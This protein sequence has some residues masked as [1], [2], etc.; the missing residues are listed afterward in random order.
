MV[1]EQ[2]MVVVIRRQG[3]PRAEPHSTVCVWVPVAVHDR[4][5]AVAARRGE[6]VSKVAADVLARSMADRRRS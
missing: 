3:R 1:S 2:S 6:S 5:I 4:L